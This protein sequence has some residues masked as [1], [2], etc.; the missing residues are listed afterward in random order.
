[1]Q[2]AQMVAVQGN[3]ER[4]IRLDTEIDTAYSYFTDFN[5]VLPRLPEIERVLRYSDGRYRMIFSADDG[6][7]HAMGIVFDIRHE[8]DANQHI[9]MLSVPVSEFD[10]KNDPRL[11]ASKAKGPLFPGSFSGETLFHDRGRHIE[12]VYRA[13]INIEIEVPRFLQF[14]P[15]KV[16]QQLGET[17]MK[18]KLNKVSEGMAGRMEEDFGEW[19]EQNSIKLIKPSKSV[20][21]FN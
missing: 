8:M 12:V 10:L 6:R 2:T 5:Y 3:F 16:L 17:L 1:M 11:V 15:R 18:V 20:A 19:Q 13:Q 21:A 9:K 7:G 14:M 4:F